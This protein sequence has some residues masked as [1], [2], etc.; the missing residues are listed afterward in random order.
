[1]TT[2]E[3]NQSVA[4][5]GKIIIAARKAIA[6]A[7]QWERTFGES[8]GIFL[9]IYQLITGVL[10]SVIA[11]KR[12]CAITST[13]SLFA[14]LKDFQAI[15]D[16]A[17]FGSPSDV[18]DLKKI[19]EQ[20]KRQ[21][22]KVV[23]LQKEKQETE[24]QM[25]QSQARVKVLI[26]E[27]STYQKT[28][29]DLRAKHENEIND[30]RLELETTKGF[31]TET[32]AQL[33]QLRQENQQLQREKVQNALVEVTPETVQ[34]IKDDFA[35]ISMLHEKVGERIKSLSQPKCTTMEIP[36]QFNRTLQNW[37]EWRNRITT[38]LHQLEEFCD[39]LELEI[40]NT[41]KAQL[42]GQFKKMQK[43][44]NDARKISVNLVRAKETGEAKL[45]KLE[46]FSR[47]AETIRNGISDDLLVEPEPV[48]DISEL[49]FAGRTT[50]ITEIPSDKQE[51][52]QSLDE[53][54]V[55]N[56][57]S[58]E[59]V[60]LISL[61]DLMRTEDGKYKKKV[62]EGVVNSAYE[63]GIIKITEWRGA[64]KFIDVREVS[65]SSMLVS[66]GQFCGKPVFMRTRTELPWDIN[67]VFTQKDIDAFKA[68][69]LKTVTKGN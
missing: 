13:D 60:I 42:N 19:A 5:T 53:I 47:A 46:A 40:E 57:M 58:Q 14:L 15:M 69:V 41:P 23:D 22:V 31:L 64:D 49:L 56:T 8:K 4:N 3:I 16:A 61:Y 9:E 51:N 21:D 67:S 62:L 38:S 32:Q 12:D 39:D 24:R 48:A 43:S 50:E 17:P 33:E 59:L 28:L 27:T 66:C 54:A 35:K 29:A 55:A 18:G 65:E 45:R 37:L 52:L 36:S 2:T 26:T 6:Q 20:I 1:M 34:Q 10:T 68:K 63:L 7:K 11:G 44:L 30:L 25:S